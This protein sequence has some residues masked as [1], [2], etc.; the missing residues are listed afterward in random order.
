MVTST[1]NNLMFMPKSCSDL[2]NFD[3]SAKQ[4]N[5]I[6]D[7]DGDGGLEP[8]IAYCD[9]ADKNGV[10][11]T[12]ISHDSENR[13]LVKEYEGKGSY[14]RDIH[15]TGTSLHQLASLTRVS[16]HSLSSMSARIP[17]CFAICMGGGCHVVLLK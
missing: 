2:K 13:T 8:F 9:M 6:I 16:S 5:Y 4:G 10:G 7:P 17:S 14:A 11:V 12:V 15:Y 1:D 3:P